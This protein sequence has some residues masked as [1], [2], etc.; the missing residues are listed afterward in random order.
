MTRMRL[1]REMRG[2][3]SR[4]A[5]SRQA[6]AASFLVGTEEV[7]EIGGATEPVYRFMRPAP[8]R[9]V[10]ADPRLDDVDKVDGPTRVRCLKAGLEDPRFAATHEGHAVVVVGAS[11]VI[12]ESAY[13]KDS[14]GWDKLRKLMSDAPRV[15]VEY[16]V[17]WPPG[18]IAASF[19]RCFCNKPLVAQIGIDLGPVAGPNEV[20]HAYPRRELLVFER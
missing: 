8:S 15:V 3:K 5:G 2:L 6:L 1:E 16:A 9:S 20:V 10:I 17:D 11:L 13:P 12:D 18:R 19:A 7:L 4:V 14:P